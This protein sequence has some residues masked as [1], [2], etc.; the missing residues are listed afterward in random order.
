MALT[1]WAGLAPMSDLGHVHIAVLHGDLGQVFFLISL[2]AAANWRP[3]RCWRPWKPVRRCWST[4]RCRRRRC[5]RPARKRGRGPDRRSRCRRP[6]RRR[7]RSTWT[8]WPGILALRIL[9][10]SQ[11]RPAFGS[12]SSSD[13]GSPLAGALALASFSPP[14]T[15][16]GGLQVIGRQF[17]SLDLPDQLL[18]G[19]LVPNVH[20][21]DRARRCPRTGSCPSGAVALLVGAVGRWQRDR[22]RWRSSRWRWR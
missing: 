19:R 12:F 10:E 21:L 15:S 5:S 17:S 20:A 22:P 1:V 11:P 6:S 2:P 3:D 8:S 14:A 18:R 9:E 7:R 13:A 16:R 4:P